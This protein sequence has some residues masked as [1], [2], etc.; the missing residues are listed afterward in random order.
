MSVSK[1][2]SDFSYISDLGMN[3]VY[4]CLWSLL[5]LGAYAYKR[6]H[7]LFQ[8]RIPPTPQASISNA[9]YFKQIE[10]EFEQPPRTQARNQGTET[11]SAAV[12]A[13]APKKERP[14]YKSKYVVSQPIPIPV[15]NQ[16]VNER[17]ESMSKII[18]GLER[19]SELGELEKLT[20][21][22][23]EEATDLIIDLQLLNE[24]IDYAYSSKIQ[25]FDLYF[26]KF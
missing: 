3:F 8:S 17:H 19:L 24:E 26:R 7:N 11:P 4:D 21:E 14:E 20:D 1:L 2:T 18:A 15:D 16:E 6:I 12:V 13:R 23:F 22:Q 9:E 10:A 25:R 5:T